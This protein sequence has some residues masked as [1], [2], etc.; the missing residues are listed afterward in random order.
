MA[1]SD[2]DHGLFYQL[3]MGDCTKRDLSSWVEVAQ[4]LRLYE[5]SGIFQQAVQ[6]QDVMSGPEY[7][8]DRPHAGMALGDALWKRAA[9]LRM[10]LEEIDGIARLRAASEAHLRRTAPEKLPLPV[11]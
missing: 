9:D 4:A 6:I 5:V 3:E 8:P 10:A 11:W 2:D 7:D 1:F